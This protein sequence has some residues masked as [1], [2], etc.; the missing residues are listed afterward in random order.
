MRYRSP[1]KAWVIITGC[2]LLTAAC[3]DNN[4]LAPRESRSA[5][6]PALNIVTSGSTEQIGDT[7]VTTFTVDNA[8]TT[9]VWMFGTAKV[10]FTPNAI[11]DLSSSYGPTE[12]DNPCEPNAAP[13]T[14]TARGWIDENGQPR[15]DFQPHM[16]FNPA[17]SPVKIWLDN[18]DGQLSDALHI[19][20]CNDAGVCYDESLTDP[21]L[22]TFRD[23]DAGQ[24]YRRIKHFSGY[25]IASGYVDESAL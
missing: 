5:S 4:A 24:Y 16:R 15:V 19:N 11:C 20:Y 14:V 18:G 10:T 25:N 9:N 13:V 23:E 3:S 1:T 22:Q 2:V 8:D 12:W 7:S 17:A 6:R 21:T